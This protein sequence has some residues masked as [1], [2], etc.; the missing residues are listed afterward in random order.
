[1]LGLVFIS[2]LSIH[3]YTSTTTDQQPVQLYIVNNHDFPPDFDIVTMLV[4]QRRRQSGLYTPNSRIRLSESLVYLA[5]ILITLSNDVN[6]NPGLTT[7]DTLYPCGT[8]DQ[9]VT[10][11]DRGI[12]CDT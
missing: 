8:C 7:T 4:N 9:P 1:M 3:K 2:V 6:L 5:V 12:I 11:E 10:W